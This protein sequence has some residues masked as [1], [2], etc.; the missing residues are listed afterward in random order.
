MTCVYWFY[1]YFP[2]NE[3]Q[4]IC[5]FYPKIITGGISIKLFPLLVYLLLRVGH[6]HEEIHLGPIWK[7]HKIDWMH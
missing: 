7:Q 6:V 5:I 3:C 1:F 4:L 2:S